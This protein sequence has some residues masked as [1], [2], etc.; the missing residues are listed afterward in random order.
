MKFVVYDTGYKRVSMN[1][2]QIVKCWQQIEKKSKITHLMNII[3]LSNPIY[4][5]N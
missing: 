3:T 1:S 5:L 2:K 4:F